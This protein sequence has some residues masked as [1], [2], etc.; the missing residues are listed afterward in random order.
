VYQSLA[1]AQ[2]RLNIS[3]KRFRPWLQAFA[4]YAFDHRSFDANEV[5]S[6]IKA[7]TDFGSD[8]WMLWNPRNNYDNTG[9]ANATAQAG[10]M[11]VAALSSLACY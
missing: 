6:Q 7:T 9:L 8:G 3:P 10:D 1:Q 2:L 5:A 11:K 4:D